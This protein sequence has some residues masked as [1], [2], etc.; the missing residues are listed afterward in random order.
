MA[1]GAIIL[2]G[3]FLIVSATNEWWSRNS[4]KVIN[5]YSIFFL[6]FSWIAR[7]REEVVSVC[8]SATRVT[9]RRYHIQR[10]YLNCF[11][12]RNPLKVTL[13]KGCPLPSDDSSYRITRRGEKTTSYLQK[14]KWWK[15]CTYRYWPLWISCLVGREASSISGSWVGRIVPRES[16]PYAT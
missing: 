16:K 10:I 6:I 8:K 1:S 2:N 11:P 5:C 12:W 13:I 14:V 15:G 9:Q 4:L 7:P 3:F